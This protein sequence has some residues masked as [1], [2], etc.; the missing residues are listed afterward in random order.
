MFTEAFDYDWGVRRRQPSFFAVV[1]AQFEPVTLPHDAQIALD[2]DPEVIDGQTNGFFPMADV[3]YEKRSTVAADATDQRQILEFEGVYRDARVYMNDG[4]AAVRPYGCSRFFVPLDQY[5]HYGASNVVRVEATSQ[6]GSRWYGGAGTYRPVTLLH[7]GALLHFAVEGPRF[8][9]PQVDTD[10]AVVQVDVSIA[11]ESP[12]TRTTRL[13]IDIVDSETGESVAKDS[14]PVIVLA[15]ESAYLRR[16]LY[17]RSSRLWGESTPHLYRDI[18]RIFD[19]FV[20]QQDDAVDDEASDTFGIRTLDLD[21]INGLRVS[22]EAVKLRGACIHHDNGPIGTAT[23]DDAEERRM[24]VLWEAG[25]N[26][27]RRA[28]NPASVALLR[29]CDKAGVFVMDETFD[30]RAS[31]KA[32]LDHAGRSLDWWERDTESLLSNNFNCPSVIM[33]SIGNEIHEARNGAAAV[34]GCEI[35]NKFRSLDLTR[36]PLSAE[37]VAFAIQNPLDMITAESQLGVNDILSSTDEALANFWASKAAAAQMEE[38][39]AH[40]AIVGYNNGD[41]KYSLDPQEFPNRVTVGG[42]TARNQIAAN[43]TKFLDSPHVIGYLCWT[44]WDYIRELGVGRV[45][46]GEQGELLGSFMGSFP[47]LAADAGDLDLVGNRRPVAY[48]REIVF[49]LRDQPWV[50]VIPPRWFNAPVALNNFGWSGAEESWTWPGDEGN[51]AHVEVYSCAEEVKLLVNGQGAG[52]RPAGAA[53]AFIVRFDVT[54]APGELTAIGYNS[55]ETGR[56][57][58]RSAGNVRMLQAE[59]SEIRADDSALTFV[60]LQLTDDTVS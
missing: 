36:F 7:R 55:H 2:R 22:G 18:V 21:P 32:L 54:Y 39:S 38:A 45:K 49:G 1:G 24:R 59:Q 33:Y 52:R 34:V 6:E 43:W 60:Q 37:K 48:F 5:L 29:A 31:R 23:I 53:H 17:V 30:V 26:A 57:T 16:R 10:L 35:A 20:D 4:L 58:L 19:A 47:Y 11:N 41:R 42:G 44:G 27:V 12:I 46:H 14:A 15:G 8:S 51:S 56:H 50:G 3:E 28:H 13:M 40:V 9:T 25:F